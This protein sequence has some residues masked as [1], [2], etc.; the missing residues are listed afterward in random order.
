M[1]LKPAAGLRKRQCETPRL[2]GGLNPKSEGRNPK[3]IRSPEIR[4]GAAGT[5]GREDGW[6][7]MQE[8]K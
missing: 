2:R 6:P 5:K 8:R 7:E 1:A 3:E 4:S